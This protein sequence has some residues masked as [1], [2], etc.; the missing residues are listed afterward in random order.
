MA[1]S[2][3]KRLIIG[4]A[5]AGM[6]CSCTQQKYF[7]KSNTF[8]TV[9]DS[10][11]PEDGGRET[12]APDTLINFKPNRGFWGE[13]KEYDGYSTVKPQHDSLLYPFRDTTKKLLSSPENPEIRISFVSKI[14]ILK[15]KY[16]I[17]DIILDSFS[18][19]TVKYFDLKP[20]LQ[21]LSTPIKIRPKLKDPALK[22]SFPSQ[23]STGVN[24]GIAF[25]WKF[26]LNYYQP[27]V[28][29][30]GLKGNKV[31]FTPGFFYGVGA[32]S[33][34]KSNTRNP[35]ISIDRSALSHTIGGFGMFGFNSINLGYSFGWDFAT[36]AGSSTWLYQGRIW[37]GVALSLDLIK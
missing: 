28:N 2:S 25:G 11:R 12:E 36:G 31:S 26:S 7:F 16:F 23:V 1:T 3:I 8:N 13:L 35:T 6:L 5:L 15:N 20:V 22:D 37:H 24:L 18:Y 33:L 9:R 30:F 19:R 17:P 21:T 34:S 14:D 32:T 10:P 27:K 29:L 4:F